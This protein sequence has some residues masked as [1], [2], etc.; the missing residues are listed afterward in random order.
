MPAGVTAQF[1]QSTVTL[2]P[3]E[4]TVNTN[5]PITLTLTPGASFTAPFTFNVVATPVGAPEFAISAPGSLLVRPQAVSI[6]QVIITPS[7]GPP[8]TQFAVTA[9][10]FAE[11]NQ[12]VYPVSLVAQLNNASGPITYDAYTS[13]YFSLTPT[14]TLQT[15]AI[16]TFDS[17]SLPNGPY[18]VSVNALGFSN[19]P[20]NG[21]NATGSFLV[22]AP[23]TATLT[24]NAN[25]TPPATVPP[26]S[27]AVQV[28][29]NITRDTSVQNPVS[30]LVGTVQLQG[31]S[32]S[33]ALYQNG[34]QQLAYAC[35][36]SYVNIV[37]V[38]NPAQMQ[39]L[40]TFANNLLTTENGN[41][42]AGFQVV[43]CNTYNNNLILSYSRYDGNTT[44]N[45]IPTHFAVFSLANPLSPAQVGSV[46]DIQRPDSLGLYVAG[47]TAL[48]Y[49][50][51]TFYDAVDGVVYQETGDVWA[52]DLSNA[53]TTGAVTY[54]N[55]IYP[56]EARIPVPAFAIT[57]PPSRLAP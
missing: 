42:V 37:D 20:F 56:A 48:M 47:S 4:A 6:D 32:R 34:Q 41:P 33:M 1:N 52:G 24:A 2:T 19:I 46:V 43:A 21:S 38:T 16:G 14:T 45:P 35:S 8:G 18:T 50:N 54:L 23:L 27:S 17:T 3:N 53:S 7:Y 5:Q 57:P 30:T 36:D 25:S 55:D 26:G 51:T 9:R 49:Q 29:L 10:V 31:I 22:G 44:P 11:V 12:S 40:G 39:V 15:I 28:A 13:A